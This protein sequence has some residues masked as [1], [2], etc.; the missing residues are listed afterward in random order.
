MGLNKIKQWS[1]SVFK[2]NTVSVI[3]GTRATGKT[4]LVKDL[5]YRISDKIDSAIVFSPTES[6]TKEYTSFFSNLFQKSVVYSEY[7]ERILQ[8]QVDYQRKYFNRRPNILVVLDNCSYHKTILKSWLLYDMF[9][10]S[11]G[12]RITCIITIQ[13]PSDVSIH[14]RSNSDYF[15]CFCAY[16]KSYRQ[17]LYKKYFDYFQN[18]KVFE[19][20]FMEHTQHYHCFVQDNTWILKT[21]LLQSIVHTIVAAVEKWRELHEYF[22]PSD[23]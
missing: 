16:N 11:R 10:N 19:K 3:I 8:E 22:Y 12:L 6:S 18:F 1:P 9:C 23:L 4:N 21:I 14:L 20:T 5:S 7:N 15:F 13:H 2:L 17:S